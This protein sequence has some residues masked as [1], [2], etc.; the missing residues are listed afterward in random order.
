MRT[1]DALSR[2]F[3]PDDGEWAEIRQIL[4][5]ILN[6]NILS[7]WSPRVIDSDDGGYRLSYDI[8]GAWKGPAARRLVTQARTVWFFAR[9]ATTVHGNEGHAAIARHGY[10]FLRDRMWDEECGGFYW[11]VDASGRHVTHP[12]KHLFAQAFGLFAVS[13]YAMTS[14]DPQRRPGPAGSS[15]FWRSTR[16]IETAADTWSSFAVTGR[17]FLLAIPVTCPAPRARRR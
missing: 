17:Y 4:L 15:A 9:L 14:R 6:E 5:R 16:T 12:H 2:P 8:R 11:E 3:Q 1:D 13:Q 10:E 7:F